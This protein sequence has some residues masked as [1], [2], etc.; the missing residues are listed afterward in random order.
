MKIKTAK[1]Y[2]ALDV[3]TGFDVTSDPANTGHWLLV[4][5]GKDGRSWTAETS[6]GGVKSYARLE[7]LMSDVKTIVGQVLPMRMSL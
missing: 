3:L 7:T 4:I 6:L 1:E 2:Y 5:S